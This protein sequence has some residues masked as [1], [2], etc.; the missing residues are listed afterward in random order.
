MYPDSTYSVIED[1]YTQAGYDDSTGLKPN[2]IYWYKV[3]SLNSSGE[4][5]N[6]TPVRAITKEV[7]GGGLTGI[8]DA[9]AGKDLLLSPNPVKAGEALNLRWSTNA[10]YGQACFVEIF[11]AAGKK[12]SWQT[13]GVPPYAPN[14]PGIYFV[15]VTAPTFRQTIKLLVN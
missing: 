3:H 4:S 1:L 9:E 12:V 10:A 13:V 6:A 15:R 7:S 11:D 14:T 2:T 8:T 5:A